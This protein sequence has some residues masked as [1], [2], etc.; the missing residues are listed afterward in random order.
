MNIVEIT[1]FKF[2]ILDITVDMNS[3]S[4]R[5]R[6]KNNHSGLLELNLVDINHC[7]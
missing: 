1:E 5:C 2:N 6:Y 4:K 3:E 7:G